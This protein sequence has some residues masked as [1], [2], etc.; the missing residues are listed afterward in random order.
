[1]LLLLLL[2]FKSHFTRWTLSASSMESC[3]VINQTQEYCTDERMVVSYGYSTDFNSWPVAL[4]Q[5]SSFSSIQLRLYPD[6]LENSLYRISSTQLDQIWRVASSLCP[7]D[8]QEVVSAAGLC[9]TARPTVQ[10]RELCLQMQR[11]CATPSDMVTDYCQLSIILSL[12]LSNWP[13]NA[14]KRSKVHTSK[15]QHHYQQAAGVQLSKT[16]SNL[17]WSVYLFRKR[18]ENCPNK[19]WITLLTSRHTDKTA[20]KT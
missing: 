20:V 19:F 15:T 9:N 16:Q 2:P 14:T 18:K 17:F 13:V 3:N 1:M 8:G 10:C 5:L 4:L 6:G 7:V 11:D 12:G